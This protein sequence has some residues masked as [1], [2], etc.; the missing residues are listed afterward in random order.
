M[1]HSQYKKVVLVVYFLVL[2]CQLSPAYAYI[3]PGSGSL[4]LQLLIG[5]LA[6]V[7]VLLKMYWQNFKAFF[8]SKK[9]K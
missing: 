5:G 1:K 6:G 9:N 4:F 3:D 2:F 8:Q 7:G